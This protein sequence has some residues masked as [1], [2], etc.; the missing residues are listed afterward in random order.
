M[1]VI[2]AVQ[3][4]IRSS[5]LFALLKNTHATSGCRD[6]E[7]LLPY[8]TCDL[9]RMAVDLSQESKKTITSGAR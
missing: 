7:L 5:V 6:T 1:V 3:F 2:N 4:R 9:V 8:D